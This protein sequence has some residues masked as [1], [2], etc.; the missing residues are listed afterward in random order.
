M[1]GLELYECAIVRKWI[2]EA[3]RIA[4]VTTI[5]STKDV[6]VPGYFHVTGAQAMAA[7]SCFN[8]GDLIWASRIGE[9]IQLGLRT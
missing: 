3:S 4:V 7:L 5:A 8:G 2:S 9:S 6:D 1:V